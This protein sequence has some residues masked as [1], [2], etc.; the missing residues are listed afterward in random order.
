MRLTMRNSH[1][2]VNLV[3]LISL[4]VLLTNDFYL[5]NAYGNFV[6]GKLSDFSGVLV[7][8]FFFTWLMNGK[9]IVAAVFVSILFFYWKL[10]YSQPLI[11]FLNETY[12]LNLVRIVD[13]GDLVALLT[14]P[15]AVL[16]LNKLQIS[17]EKKW[18]LPFFLPICFF[19]ITATSMP[20]ISSKGENS[21]VFYWRGNEA[22]Y[23][24]FVSFE[25]LKRDFEAMGYKL[26]II[27]PNRRKKYNEVGFHNK[28]IVCNSKELG[29]N[30]NGPIRSFA[31]HV[32]GSRVHS[33]VVLEELEICG[34]GIDYQF[35][36][37]G[38]Y[39]ALKQF[40]E[41]FLIKYIKEYESHRPIQ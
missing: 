41:K 25:D 10:S 2:I 13:Y 17:E 35:N 6:T 37:E 3:C 32:S 18:F 9:K 14:L 33:I 21:T 24:F 4:L 30:E 34:S 40:E 15:L 29:G 20:R 22:S 8:F 7:A 26:A 12:G 23:T 16:Y 39:L 27:T 1:L 36:F 11:D 19:S 5:K 28:S 38:R 31:I